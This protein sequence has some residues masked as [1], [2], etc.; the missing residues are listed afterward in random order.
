MIEL[1]IPGYNTEWL[2]IANSKITIE[3]RILLENG[4][5]F[6]TDDAEAVLNIP[7]FGPNMFSTI[8]VSFSSS[9]VDNK[10]FN[11]SKKNTY[12]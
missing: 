2:D 5:P 4:Q 7:L 12:L 11:K 8:K 1:N 9:S 10:S 3:A 6:T